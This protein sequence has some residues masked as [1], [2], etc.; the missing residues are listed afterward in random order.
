MLNE[1]NLILQNN[2][3]IYKFH[4]EAQSALHLAVK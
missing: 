1:N 4:E 3:D 2:I